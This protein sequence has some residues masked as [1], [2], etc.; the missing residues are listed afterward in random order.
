MS[1]RRLDLFF[2]FAIPLG[3]VLTD[4]THSFAGLQPP[5]RHSDALPRESISLLDRRKVPASISLLGRTKKDCWIHIFAEKGGAPGPRSESRFVS[6]NKSE[7][8]DLYVIYGDFLKWGYPLVI[9]FNGSSLIDHPAMG[10]PHDYGNPHIRIRSPFENSPR[11][12][13]LWCPTRWCPPSY[14]LVY[15]PYKY[16]YNTHKP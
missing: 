10:V 12:F 8:Y 14:K 16:R 9:H 5:T 2:R 1:V 13:F 6:T 4:E 7:N 3:V 11:L 15:K